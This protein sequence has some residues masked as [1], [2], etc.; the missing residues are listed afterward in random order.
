MILANS[1]TVQPVKKFPSFKGPEAPLQFLQGLATCLSSE[2]DESS[3]LIVFLYDPFQYEI[4]LYRSLPGF[5]II[6][7]F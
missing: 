3:P 5:P 6:S 7:F 2:P 1:V 4:L